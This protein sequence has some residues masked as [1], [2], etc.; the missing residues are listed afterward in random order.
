MAEPRLVAGRY[1][2]REPLGERPIRWLAHD[3]EQDRTVV[4]TR[5]ETGATGSASDEIAGR[6]GRPAITTARALAGLDVPSVLKPTEA[7][8]DGGELWVVRDHV[9]ASSLSEL[10]L[11][12][13]A[14][15][16]VGADV[17]AAL[18]A[19]HGAGVVHGDVRAESVF[20]RPDG[21]GALA[22]F[23]TVAPRDVAPN[24]NHSAH[25]EPERVPGRPAVPAGDV[26][27]LGAMLGAVLERAGITPSERMA[28]A[29]DAMRAERADL[30]PTARAA[31]QQLTAVASEP[32]PEAHSQD[33]AQP[34]DAAPADPTRVR[35]DADNAATSIAVLPAPAALPAAGQQS[36]WAAPQPVQGDGS[37]AGWWPPDGWPPGDARGP[38]GHPFG[39]PPGEFVSPPPNFPTP[40]S[41]PSNARSWI[42]A[43]IAVFAALGIAAAVIAVVQPV[44]RVTGSGAAPPGT[45]PPPPS[46]LGDLPT[47]DPCSLLDA[48]K[49]TRV[50]RT[51]PAADF[52]AAGSCGIAISRDIDSGYVTAAIVAKWRSLPIGTPSQ[53]GDLTIYKDTEYERSCQRTIVLPDGYRVELY[54]AASTDDT[55]FPVCVAADAATED[56]VAIIRAGKVGHR[57]LDTP[58]NSLLSVR[59]C[60]VLDP[61]TLSS[62]P[63][64][65]RLRE[66]GYHDWSCRYGVDPSIPAGSG[67]WVN[68]T[69]NRYA[70]LTGG[71]GIFTLD[72]R[73]ANTFTWTSGEAICEAVVAQRNF[74]SSAGSP[75]IEVLSVQVSLASDQPGSSPTAACQKATDL[76][77]T[78]IPRLPP[79]Q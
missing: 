44:V 40:R 13:R 27:G 36:S 49:L 16:G 5:V 51:E 76:V 9:E 23:G 2:L 25:P 39:N 55:T 10:Q 62:V 70:D 75:R 61:A 33:A 8:I 65:S 6:A 78:A 28:A 41:G 37:P 69:F 38:G 64:L 60:D 42:G 24:A 46:L 31:Q 4:L 79:T 43:A 73:A 7:M 1:Q 18:A 19:A 52:G 20:V 67:A 21:S 45:S 56:A 26:Y 29:L 3:Q 32:A 72:G 30:R 12:E 48:A 22:G 59:A 63:S 17:A 58:R 34:P 57:V 11:D 53:N 66:R 35:Q 14:L 47:A 54:S 77:R 15:A 71:S 74:T 50:G 68:V